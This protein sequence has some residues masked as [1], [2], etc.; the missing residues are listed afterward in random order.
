MIDNV[1]KAVIADVVEKV[2][3][4]IDDISDGALAVCQTPESWYY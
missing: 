2:T 3:V 4:T 1:A